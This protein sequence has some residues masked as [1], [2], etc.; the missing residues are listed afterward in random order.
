MDMELATDCE[1]ADDSDTECVEY[2]EILKDTKSMGDSIQCVG[3]KKWL[4]EECT[5]FPNYYFKCEKRSN[6]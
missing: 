6:L 1:D 5:S 4:H 3:F 2:G